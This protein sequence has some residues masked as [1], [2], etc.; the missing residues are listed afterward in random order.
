[1]GY[2]K[3]QRATIGRPAQTLGSTGGVIEATPKVTICTN[4]ATGVV[5]Q[6]PT[7]QSGLE[8][9]VIL[10]YLGATGSVTFAN[11]STGTVF[12]G[13]TNNVITVSSSDDTLVLTFVGVSTT[14]WA[15]SSSTGSGVTL[16][17]STVV[18]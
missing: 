4:T 6:L 14:K 5:Y 17:A 9:T 10:D 8:K 11:K 7:P 16:S 13:T 15:V 2:T 1:M 3:E 18:D 12:N